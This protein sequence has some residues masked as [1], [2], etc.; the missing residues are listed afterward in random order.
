MDGSLENKTDFCMYILKKR[1]MLFLVYTTEE[2]IQ[3]SLLSIQIDKYERL[4]G[5]YCHKTGA[6]PPSCNHLDN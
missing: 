1:E 5:T 6:R 2:S 4:S 3:T